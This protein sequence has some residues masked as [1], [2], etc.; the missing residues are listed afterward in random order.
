MECIHRGK[1]ISPD[2]E[3]ILCEIHTKREINHQEFIKIAKIND[4]LSMVLDQVE[5]IFIDLQIYLAIVEMF[6]NEE[7]A[8]KM[9]LNALKKIQ[10]DLNGEMKNLIDRFGKGTFFSI[11]GK[12]IN[13]SESP[14]YSKSSDSVL[15]S[16]ASLPE[17]H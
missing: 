17:I 5:I 10:E 14:L 7:K 4:Y 1:F 16:F 3:R 9:D 2:F 11:E 6:L 15:F 8:L 12:N 13:H